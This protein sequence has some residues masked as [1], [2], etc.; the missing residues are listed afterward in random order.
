MQ[1]SGLSNMKKV[2][3]ECG[4][5]SPNIIFD[6]C[7]NLDKAAMGSANAIF[8]NQ[9]EVC[10]AASRLIVHNR[11]KDDTRYVACPCVL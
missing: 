11:I 6:D 4:G 10:I 1:Y 5:K 8:F 7:E 3:T 9:G 2:Y